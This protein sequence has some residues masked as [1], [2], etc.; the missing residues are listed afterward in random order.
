GTVE[1]TAVATRE[2]PSLGIDLRG[3]TVDRVTV[4]GLD[5]TIVRSRRMLALHPA[6]PIANAATFRTRVANHGV[7]KPLRVEGIPSGLIATPDGAWVAGEPDGVPTWLPVNDHPSDKATYAFAIT[8]PKGNV[9]LANGVFAARRTRA[10]RTTWRWREDDPMASYLA[11][12]TNGRFDYRVGRGPG[13]LPIYDAVAPER[14]TPAVRRV[15]ALQP[16]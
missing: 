1:M 9:A 3:M 4:D 16:A 11:T 15:L 2:L 8:V 6:Q 12:A 13:G 7:P 5:A 10:G 14:D